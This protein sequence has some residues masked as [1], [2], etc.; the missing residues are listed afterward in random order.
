MGLG[1]LEGYCACQKVAGNLG[2]DKSLFISVHQGAWTAQRCSLDSLPNL[3]P[4]PSL[5]FANTHF[6]KHTHT[7]TRTLGPCDYSVPLVNC[8]D[9]PTNQASMQRA[10]QQ[11][12]ARRPR[13]GG[14]VSAPVIT[15]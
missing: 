2:G 14:L 7:Y 6:Y 10:S 4:Q 9:R 3:L 15:V 1:V 12:N 5:S 11:I 13:T 8:T